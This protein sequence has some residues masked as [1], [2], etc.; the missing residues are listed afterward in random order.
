MSV[1]FRW[2]LACLALPTLLAVRSSPQA[3]FWQ[4]F[5][6]TALLCI[7]FGLRAG[8][9]G[10][11]IALG[12][13]SMVATATG[14]L[15]GASVGWVAGASSS[16]GVGL[17]IYLSVFAVAAL[18]LSCRETSDDAPEGV[19]DAIALGV[20]SAALLQSVVGALQLCGSE[21]GGLVLA[22]VYR[23]AYGNVGQ[24]NHYADLLS[25]GLA[26]IPYCAQRWRWHRW[27]TGLVV[28]W[29]AFS[30]A[31]SASR[32][33]WFY[34]LAFVVLGYVARSARGTRAR[35]AGTR[36]AMVGV[37]SLL[38]QIVFANSGLLDRL[39]VTSS[40]ARAADGGSNGQRL[41]DWSLALSAIKAHPW[42]GV[43][44]GGF[45]GWAIEQMAVTPSVPF[46]KFAEHAHN[47]PLHL[48]ATMGL[49]FTVLCL[50]GLGWW[51]VRQLRVP[52]TPERLFAFC[53]LSVIGLHSMVEYPLWYTYFII[54]AGL[55]CGILASTD[56]D[57]RTVAVPIWGA[58]AMAVLFALGVI[59]VGRDYWVVERAYAD[60][61]DHGGVASAADR[62]RIRTELATVPAWSIVG[63]HA[64]SLML[65]TW[66]PDAETA[67]EMVR[68]CEPAFK[69]RP[70]WGLGTHCLLAMGM[71]GDRPAVERMSKVLCEGFP[72][73]HA[74]LREWAATA[75]AY[76]PTLS[77]RSSACLRAR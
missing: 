61:S 42:L 77:V 76:R 4:E 68:A 14:V 25:L 12:L 56:P 73:H 26:A 75:D 46:S 38:T 58:R 48:A 37:A 17:L 6:C 21:V 13:P 29:L 65:Q 16:A 32:A 64:Q 72:R 33:P 63:D 45:H 2:L 53:G 30:I 59:W 49:P 11:R 7:A 35:E 24:A 66:Q 70:S 8:P 57:A 52:M 54:P 15:V 18:M 28:A 3:V 34:M 55:F 50:G 40:I 67:P 20:L 27:S 10:R 51:L 41:Y 23:Q 60:W 31:A 44:V 1:R 43:G 22:K 62:T 71:A 69:A 19:V 36:I 5:A 47:L 74:M 39:G 9:G